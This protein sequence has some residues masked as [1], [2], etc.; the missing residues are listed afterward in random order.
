LSSRRLDASHLVVIVVILQNWNP[1][2]NSNPIDEL[3]ALWDR[4][5]RDGR[6]HEI[7]QWDASGDPKRLLS[8]VVD[9]HNW[10][11]AVQEGVRFRPENNDN[12]AVDIMN[13]AAGNGSHSHGW[14]PGRVRAAGINK[15]DAR[16]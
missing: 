16:G 5:R 8:L 15:A 13:L 12:I 10:A 14:G 9:V 2:D 3:G 11:Y 4:R 6:W 1:R 7:R